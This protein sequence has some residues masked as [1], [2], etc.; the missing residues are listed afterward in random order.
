VNGELAVIEAHPCETPCDFLTLTQGGWH[1]KAWARTLGALGISSE[2]PVIIG[3]GNTLTF[4]TPSVIQAFLPASGTPAAITASATDPAPR[5]NTLAGQL[6]TLTLNVRNNPA[7]ETSAGLAGAILDP[8]KVAE[9]ISGGAAQEILLIANLSSTTPVTVQMVLDRANAIFG[10]ATTT[11][12]ELANMTALLDLINTSWH[13]GVEAA[14][15]I[16]SCP[17]VTPR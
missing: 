15:P 12:S 2:A 9:C 11:K 6:L 17:P 1:N 16:L 7:S 3:S 5:K 10:G 14:C 13:E 4:T 8:A